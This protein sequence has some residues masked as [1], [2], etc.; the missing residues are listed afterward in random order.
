MEENKEKQVIYLETE[1]R[2]AS[3][4]ARNDFFN[5]ELNSRIECLSKCLVETQAE[6]I[7]LQNMVHWHTHKY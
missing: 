5:F 3:E 4:T 7:K 1:E 2:V 6:F